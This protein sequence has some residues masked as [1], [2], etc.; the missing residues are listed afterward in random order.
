ME[1]ID[2]AR[3]RGVKVVGETC[4]QYLMLTADD[5]DRDGWE[6]AKFVCSPPPRDEASKA[7]CWQGLEQ[8]IFDLYSSDH[9]P[10]RFDDPEGKLNEKGKTQFP[11]DPERHPRG[12]DAP[13]DPV[14][15]RRD[16]GAHRPAALCRPDRDQ[17]CQA[18]RALSPQRAPLRS[19]SDADLTLWDPKETRTITND[20]PPSR[21]RLHAL[22]RHEGHR[23][24]RNRHPARQG[25]RASR[26][27]ATCGRSRSLCDAP[28]QRPGKSARRRL[29]RL[30]G[31][32]GR[33]LMRKP[34]TRGAPADTGQVC[35]ACGGN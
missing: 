21:R 35:G 8:G 26:R 29:N 9:C 24:A 30:A 3:K 19:G 22:R 31:M 20:D 27:T 23:L 6:G 13:A 12:R 18:L 5:L 10:F 11:L 7:A 33:P 17:P 28:A 15:R 34:R 25:R 2:R 4:P 32:S 16:E 1:E 14:F